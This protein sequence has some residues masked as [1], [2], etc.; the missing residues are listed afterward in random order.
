MWKQKLALWK[1][2]HVVCVTVFRTRRE[3]RKD[4]GIRFSSE[5]RL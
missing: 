2:A 4:P 1:R 3:K 5:G